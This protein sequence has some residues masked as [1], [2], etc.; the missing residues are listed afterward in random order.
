[1]SGGVRRDGNG[2]GAHL[3]VGPV[4]KA[5]KPAFILLSLLILLDSL[6]SVHVPMIHPLVIAIGV[7]L[8]FDQVLMLLLPSIVAH[9]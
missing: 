5:T 3:C 6:R 1:M 8:P 9:T 2:G 4:H 7:P